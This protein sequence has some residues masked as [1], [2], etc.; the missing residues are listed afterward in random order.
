[1]TKVVGDNLIM[2][3]RKKLRQKFGYPQG[4]YIYVCTHSYTYIC[5]YL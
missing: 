1:M 4:E 3:V 5:V 2:H